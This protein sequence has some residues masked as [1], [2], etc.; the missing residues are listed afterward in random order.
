[1]GKTSETIARDRLCAAAVRPTRR[2]LDRAELL[3]G[4][5]CHRHV[6]SESL[7]AAAWRNGVPVSLATVYNTPRT[8]CATGVLPEIRVDTA[9]SC[10]DTCIDEHPRY[11]L[12]KT[13]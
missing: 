13:G 9:Q 6:I 8:F 4:D 7:Y 5:G 2:R 10:F 3:V 12:G 1:M 11:F